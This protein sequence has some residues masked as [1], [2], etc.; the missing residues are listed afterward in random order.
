MK[1]PNP[2]IIKRCCRK[3]IASDDLLVILANLNEYSHLEI[4]AL[5]SIFK[6]LLK[7]GQWQVS[8]VEVY[9]TQ[10]VRKIIES[11]FGNLKKIKSDCVVF[12]VCKSLKRILKNDKLNE[13]IISLQ[14]FNQLFVLTKNEKFVISFEAFK[15]LSVS[16]IFH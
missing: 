5:Y 11:L 4:K 7:V 9:F 14:F 12:A 3:L 16:N 2:D 6:T 1:D 8:E 13:I 15:I 10:N